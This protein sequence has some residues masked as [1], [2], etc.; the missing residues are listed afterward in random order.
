MRIQ[1][2]SLLLLCFFLASHA[3]TGEPITT[4][5]NKYTAR[6]M[7]FDIDITSRLRPTSPK[8]NYSLFFAA[9]AAVGTISETSHLKW[10]PQQQLVVPIGYTKKI[11]GF[12]K[13]KET[14]LFFDW[15]KL[16]INDTKKNTKLPMGGVQRIQDDLSYQL[17]LRQDLIAGKKSFVY[18][19][20]EGGRITDTVFSLVGEEV[21]ST[22]LGN[23]K[24]LKIKRKHPNSD[25]STYAWFA[26]K[27][28]YLLVR[29]QQDNNGIA[30]TMDI[31]KA[32]L[33]GKSIAR[34]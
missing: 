34:F 8:G 11:D 15:T 2:T 32:S 5:E 7:G 33:N 24:T 13:S 1:Y 3:H 27:Y 18:N 20:G 29:L 16:T 31:S 23:V 19:I 17:Q 21:I 10:N 25:R 26:P 14:N 22:P 12:G 4:F 9:T 30:Y 28:Q 6:L